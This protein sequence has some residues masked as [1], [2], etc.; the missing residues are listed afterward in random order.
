[1]RAARSIITDAQ[2]RA[3]CACGTWF[4]FDTDS[5]TRARRQRASAGVSL[6]EI[7][8]IGSSERYPADR[9]GGRAHISQCH[10]LRRAG[11]ANGHSTEIQTGG[12]KLGG[13]ADAAKRHLLR[14]ARSTIRDAQSCS[15]SAR[16][17][18]LELNAD[19]AAR[20]CGQR[21]PA[22]VS[23]CE[24]RSVSPGYRNSS[25]G[26]RSRCQVCKRDCFCCASH[27]DS[28]RAKVQTGGRKLRRRADSTERHLLR[29]PR[30]IIRDAQCCAARA[31]R[32]RLKSHTEGAARTCSQRTSAGMSL[33]EIRSVGP[34]D[35]NGSDRHRGCARILKRH[36]LGCAGR[37]YDD[38][39][40]AQA[41]RRQCYYRATAQ[42][43]GGRHRFR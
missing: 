24:V 7:A 12:R 43:E 28:N 35:R 14:A 10:G 19:R 13:G 5:A 2:S 37:S 30:S 23:L 4:E 40:E 29:A 17:R 41:R 26:Q 3:T 25:D 16:S 15:T 32:S 27:G 1:L 20:A 36:C 39:S 38:R 31:A 6:R 8:Y 34:G 21:S 9:Q 33:C 11:H 22:R 18:G 42:I